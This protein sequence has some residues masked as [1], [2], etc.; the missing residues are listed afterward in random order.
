[1]SFAKISFGKT[2]LAIS[3]LDATVKGNY[4]RQL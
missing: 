2:F 4:G 1:M 3:D